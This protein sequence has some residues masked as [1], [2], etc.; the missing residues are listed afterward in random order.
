VAHS[1][2]SHERRF[3]FPEHEKKLLNTEITVE[4][5]YPKS[6]PVFVV[7]EAFEI[8]PIVSELLICQ[9]FNK[10]TNKIA[11]QLYSRKLDPKNIPGFK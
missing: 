8:V 3:L 11:Q 5:A 4:K 10:P 2:Y 6:W 9:C 7:Y 1:Y